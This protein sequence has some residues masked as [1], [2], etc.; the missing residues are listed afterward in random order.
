MEQMERLKQVAGKYP[1]GARLISA[2]QVNPSL[3][4]GELPGLVAA[5]IQEASQPFKEV[6]DQMKSLDGCP[7]VIERQ[8][9]VLPR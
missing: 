5:V 7:C 8:Q 3:A 6:V 1:S 9:C 2:L 4:S